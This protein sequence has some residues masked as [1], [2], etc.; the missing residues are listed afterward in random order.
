VD[1]ANAAAFKHWKRDHTQPRD[2]CVKERQFRARWSMI[3]NSKITTLLSWILM[4]ND[5]FF[6]D[7]DFHTLVVVAHETGALSPWALGLMLEHFVF[8]ARPLIPA[9]LAHLV[10]PPHNVEYVE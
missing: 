7:E 1:R 4:D 10:V 6:I 5:L 2:T 3:S 9:V 8:K